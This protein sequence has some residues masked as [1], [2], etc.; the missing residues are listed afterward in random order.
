MLT[1]L[2]VTLP[3]FLGNRDDSL[4][5]LRWLRKLPHVYRPTLDGIMWILT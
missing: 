2:T 3:F 4:G 5:A 1:M